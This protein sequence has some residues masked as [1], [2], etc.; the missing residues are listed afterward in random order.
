MCC[1]HLLVR[2]RYSGSC[3]INALLSTPNLHILSSIILIE[4][5]TV[6]DI[7]CAVYYVHSSHA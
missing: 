6:K 7:F 2:L 4:C 3:C 5:Y 1:V